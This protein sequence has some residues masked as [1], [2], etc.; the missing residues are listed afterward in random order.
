MSTQASKNPIDNLLKSNWSVIDQSRTA[1]AKEIASLAN[2]ISGPRSRQ[3]KSVSRW[4][5]SSQDYDAVLERPDVLCFCQPWVTATLGKANRES[6]TESEMA[7]AIG[8]GFLQ[9]REQRTSTSRPQSIL[10]SADRV[11]GLGDH[12]RAGQHLSAPSVSHA[13]RGIRYCITAV[14][15]VYYRKGNVD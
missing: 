3:L 5:N 6:L 2:S 13:V 8:A 1:M 7:A 9:I 4:L 12:N 11:D 15:A 14:Y 10:L